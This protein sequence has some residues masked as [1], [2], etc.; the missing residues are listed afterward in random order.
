MLL[1]LVICY[2]SCL[3]KVIYTFSNFYV[4]MFVIMHEQS[5]I[6]LLC[7]FVW[8]DVDVDFH[9]FVPLHGGIEVEIFDINSHKFCVFGA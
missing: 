6:I 1:E 9:I 2:L 4:N 7:N 3:R 8:Y 5:Q